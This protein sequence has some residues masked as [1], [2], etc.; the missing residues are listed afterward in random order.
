MRAVHY[1]PEFISNLRTALQKRRWNQLNLA[2]RAGVS[3]ASVSFLLNG[4]PIGPHIAKRIS[5]TLGVRLV[6]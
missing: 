3:T 1:P 2:V 5:E 6:T 4:K